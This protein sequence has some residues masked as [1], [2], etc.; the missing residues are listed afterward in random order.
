[1]EWIRC[2]RC[3]KF[4]RNFV[5]RTCALMAPVRSVLHRLLCGN[6]TIKNIPKHEFWLQWSGLGALVVKNSNTS[7][8][9]ELMRLW[10]H[11]GQFCIDFHVVTKQFETCQNMSFGSNGVDRVRSLRK[12]PMKLRLVNLCVN[13]ASSASFASSFV[14]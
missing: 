4:R 5:Q 1:M 8:F 13:G 6:K 14:K 2:V 10:R 11:F 7:S 12:Y 9:S 3:E